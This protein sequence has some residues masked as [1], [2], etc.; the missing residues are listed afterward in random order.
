MYVDKITGCLAALILALYFACKYR[1]N[2]EVMNI[3]QFL[4][5]RHSTQ[6]EYQERLKLKV[7]HLS[8]RILAASNAQTS[9]LSTERSAILNVNK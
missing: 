7:Y 3:N 1:R 5:A 9:F 6:Y 8:R 4:S 2:I